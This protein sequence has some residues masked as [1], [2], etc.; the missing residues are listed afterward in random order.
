MIVF[1]LQKYSFFYKKEIYKEKYILTPHRHNKS[2]L[3]VRIKDFS[4]RKS[5]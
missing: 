4:L 5:Q 1:E 2:S 3:I